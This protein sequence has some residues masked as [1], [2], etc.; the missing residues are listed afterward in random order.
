MGLWRPNSR[1]IF[2]PEERVY[3]SKPIAIIVLT[4]TNK[5]I[6]QPVSFLFKIVTN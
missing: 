4:V 6:N 1:Y 3:I 5:W 2:A